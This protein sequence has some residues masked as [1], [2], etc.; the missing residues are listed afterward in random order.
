MPMTPSPSPLHSEI[1]A[2]FIAVS[3]IERARDW[4]C[5]L[6]G[7][8]R[9]GEISFGHLYCIP[10]KNG[11]NLVLD[12]KI[13]PKRTPDDAPLFHFNTADIEASYRYLEG[14]GVELVGPI[15]HGHWFTFK[16]PDG[17]LLMAAKC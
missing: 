12:S 6:L 2:I 14:L 7:L 13:F 16:D 4:Y 17:N 10:M 3:D 11:S 9:D 15:Q 1:G 5:Q 8:P